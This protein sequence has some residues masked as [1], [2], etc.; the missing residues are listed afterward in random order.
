MRTLY[1]NDSLPLPSPEILFNSD[2][3]E[4]QVYYPDIN[5]LYGNFFIK[6][7]LL[8]SWRKKSLDFTQKTVFSGLLV[9]GWVLE[10]ERFFSIITKYM[11]LYVIP[12][13]A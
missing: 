7:L 4:S 11:L 1:F 9:V 8:F 5:P 3:S 12:K 6:L 2:I 10:K 13:V